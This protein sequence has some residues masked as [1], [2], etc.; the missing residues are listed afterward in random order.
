MTRK[1]LGILLAIFTVSVMLRV[2]TALYLGDIVD[3]PPLLTDQRSYDALG[4]RL[5]TGHGFS[6]D[7]GWY[8][9]TSADTPTAHWSFLYSL[10]VA[11]VYALFGPHP[12]AVRVV[13]GI[14]GGILLPWLVYRLTYRLYYPASESRFGQA[15]ANRGFNADRLALLAAAIAAVYLYFVLYAATLMTETFFICGL[16][17]ILEQ[18]MVLAEA[19]TWQRG[20]MLG[21]GL[22]I[23]TLLRQSILPWVAVMGVWLLWVAVKHHTM[24]RV[25][26][27]LLT[28]LVILIAFIVPFTI[29]NYLVYHE[30]LLLNSNAGYAMF[31]AQNPMHGTTFQEFEGAPM[32]PDLIGVGLNEAQLDRELMRRGIGFV[33]AEPGRYILLSLSRAVD[34][35]QFWPTSDTTLL[36]NI[37]RVSSFGVFMPF[38]LYGLFLALRYALQRSNHVKVT[39]SPL[40]LCVLFILTYSALHIFTWA[41]PRYR[42]PVDAVMLSFAALGLYQIAHWRSEHFKRPRPM[43][44]AEP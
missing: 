19:P 3:A 22:G 20:L 15:V 41:M 6:F 39:T 43:V 32:P 31:S 21:I 12:L 40:M 7:R 8:P 36:N 4:A 14:L 11:A 38:M 24:R 42:L 16:L 23:T 34:Y 5:I 25:V 30:F 17:F 33:L 18:A 29:R 13:Q 35:F 28:A 1:S 10:F 27:A 9:F 44:A 37:G 26:T 2:G